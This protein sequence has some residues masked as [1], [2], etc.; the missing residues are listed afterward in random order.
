M[1]K[2][3]YKGSWDLKVIKEIQ[4]RKVLKENVG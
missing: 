4:A 3:A 2:W 1:V